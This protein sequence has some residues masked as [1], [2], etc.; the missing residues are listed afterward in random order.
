MMSATSSRRLPYR[1]NGVATYDATHDATYDIM[2]PGWVAIVGHIARGAASSQG[3]VGSRRSL[4]QCK[5]TRICG[6]AVFAARRAGGPP[7][8]SCSGALDC[9]RSACSW[10][11]CRLREAILRPASRAAHR[12][13]CSSS[14]VST[15][16]YDGCPKGSSATCSSAGLMW[17]SRGIA[18][19]GC[20]R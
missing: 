16:P 1:L 5:T 2:T 10:H 17:C 7:Q 11:T 14:L 13:R 9:G 8:S 6:D 18:G 15:M 19:A 20:D 4:T 12:N 3:R